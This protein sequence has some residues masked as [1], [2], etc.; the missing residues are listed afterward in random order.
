MRTS[1][2]FVIVGF[3]ALA[4]PP[5]AHNQAA[6]A[7]V[8]ATLPAPKTQFKDCA[9][10]PTMVVVPAGSFA[11]GGALPQAEVGAAPADPPTR[12]VPQRQVTISRPFAVGKFEV[13][14]GEW[15]ACVAGGGCNGY[16][17]DDEGWG[18]GNM[19][20][21]NVTWSEAQAYVQWLSQKTGKP[22]RLLSEAEWEYAARSGTSVRYWWGQTN[23]NGNANCQ[24]CGSRWD[25]K[26]IAPTGSFSSNAFGL[27][28]MLGNVWEWT[29]DCDNT[30]SSA[31]PS[32]GSPLVSGDCSMRV[33]RGG[34]WN[35]NPETLGMTSRVRES[36][37]DRRHT[38]GLRVA[39]TN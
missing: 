1:S 31:A 20:V 19:P 8:T 36:N 6:A 33:L 27:H 12:T 16:R 25:N 28:E 11:M 15:D 5:W 17:P 38:T 4:L 29:Q 21:M 23:T 3:A 9:D 34:S 18:R 26:Q 7:A 24:G 32:D 2:T 10:C 22:Y 35:N 13:T 14:F 39:R 30:N 37:A